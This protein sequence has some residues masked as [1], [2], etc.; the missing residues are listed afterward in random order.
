MRFQKQREVEL[1]KIEQQKQ[2]LL[3]QIPVLEKRN[4]DLEQQNK[5]LQSKLEAK[6]QEK[7]RLASIITSYP[8]GCDLYRPLVASYGWPVDQAMKIMS[9][10][11]GCNP[12]ALSA[13]QDRGLFQIN[14]CHKAKVG[15]DL[16]LLYDPKTNVEVAYG[17]WKA[18]GWQPWSTRGVLG[19]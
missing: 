19:I 13:T 7:A 8:A 4:Q 14:Q 16:A 12:N 17:I 18:Q 9:A 2:E 6:A 11:S 1:N 10:E 3:E 5:D 15:G